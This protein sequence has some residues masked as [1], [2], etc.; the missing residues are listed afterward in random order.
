[1]RPFV[2]FAGETGDFGLKS[3]NL[4]LQGSDERL[5]VRDGLIALAASGTIRAS[6]SIH[7][8]SV[9]GDSPRSC[10]ENYL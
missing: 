1:L 10:A 5:Q 4:S 8:V 7:A 6:G 9:A 2:E 3:D